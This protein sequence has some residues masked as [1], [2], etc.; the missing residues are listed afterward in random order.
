MHITLI[1]LVKAFRES[2]A[3]QH[4][5]CVSCVSRYEITFVVLP[6]GGDQMEKAEARLLGEILKASKVEFKNI[7]IYIQKLLDGQS[8]LTYEEMQFVMKDNPT[9]KILSMNLKHELQSSE[10][11]RFTCIFFAL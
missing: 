10:L 3:L 2:I 11:Q 7:H 6:I 8:S 4:K 9:T 5:L 1:L